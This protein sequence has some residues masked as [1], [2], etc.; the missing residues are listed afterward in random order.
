MHSIAT[1][2][3]IHPPTKTFL[4]A[5]FQLFHK[6]SIWD[7]LLKLKSSAQGWDN[8]ARPFLLRK[9]LWSRLRRQDE[10]T[11]ARGRETGP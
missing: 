11:E 9:A 3:G 1:L 6:A 10:K 2:K 8:G 7:T 5:D 4:T